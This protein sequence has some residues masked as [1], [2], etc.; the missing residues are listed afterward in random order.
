MAED[1]KTVKRD[2]E[3][4]ISDNGGT[5]PDYYIGITKHIE[6]RLVEAN[7]TI[8]EHIR[9]GEYT[10]G[11]PIYT[12]ECNT[13]DEAVKIER[14]F[15]EKGMLKLNLR[16][17]GVEDSKFIYC[18]KMTEENKRMVLNENSEAGKKMITSI[19]KFKEFI[20]DK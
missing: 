1:I 4:F 10:E 19:K 8:I 18:Y 2:I 14:F 12:V 9:N 13:R 16:S 6:Q 17:F 3:A 11:N 15:Q 20:N 5:Y 7:E